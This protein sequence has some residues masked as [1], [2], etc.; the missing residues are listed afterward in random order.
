MNGLAERVDPERAWAGTVAALVAILTLGSIVFPR[1]VYDG[2][3]WQYFWGPVEADARGY[4]CL[5]RIDGQ[6]VTGD[7]TAAIVA[8]P[9]YTTISTVSYGLVLVL[10]LVGVYFLMERLEIGTDREFLYAMFPFVLFGGALR[11]VED[12]S[13]AVREAGV[14]AAVIPFPWSALIISPFIYFTV[15][16]LT[17][18]SILIG[19]AI[20][21]RTERSIPILPD[22][23]ADE[24]S[25]N[26]LST[27]KRGA[28]EI[29]RKQQFTTITGALGTGLLVLALGYLVWLTLTTDVLTFNWLILTIT[30]VGAT[31][32]TG[33]VWIATQDGIQGIDVHS[34]T[35]YAGALIIWG[36]TVDGIA[37]VLSL[38]WNDELGLQEYQPKHVVNSGVRVVTDAIQPASVSEAIGITWPF[39]I[40]KVV[41]A[42]GVVALFNDEVFDESPRYTVLLL[43]TVLAV[44]L[45]PGT[46]DVLRA[47]FGI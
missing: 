40:I 27:A 2:F 23:G 47:T 42:V 29:K 14:D 15:F 5:A 45:G 21:R 46:R 1:Q 9:G 35:D 7:C 12:A 19:V 37:N 43:I 34:G 17:V 33:L 18:L 26:E 10:M 8:E 30:F 25:D 3:L 24:A 38:D 4:D 39:L 13:L 36:H 22:G 44:G 41:A 16:A 28:V 20:S 31:V 32:L 11:T 6:T